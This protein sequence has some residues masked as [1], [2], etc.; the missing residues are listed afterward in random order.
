MYF[1]QKGQKLVN[2]KTG[3]K[4]L[5][6]LIQIRTSNYLLREIIDDFKTSLSALTQQKWF[7]M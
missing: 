7:K 3:N 2:N 5:T 6:N 4:I 1:T